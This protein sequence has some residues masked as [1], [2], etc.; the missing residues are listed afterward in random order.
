MGKGLIE[1][2]SSAQVGLSSPNIAPQGQ[3]S[4]TSGQENYLQHFNPTGKTSG[5]NLEHK[6]KQPLFGRCGI[7]QWPC[8]RG[9]RKFHR[10]L[11]QHAIAPPSESKKPRFTVFLSALKPKDSGTVMLKIFCLILSVKLQGPIHRSPSPSACLAVPSLDGSTTSEP[12][13]HYCEAQQ[14]GLSG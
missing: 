11:T 14:C 6:R 12:S 4:Q 5:T 13:G 3:Q 10:E 1:Y 7:K 2:S 9:G 8:I